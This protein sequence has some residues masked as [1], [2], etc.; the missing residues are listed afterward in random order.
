MESRLRAPLSLSCAVGS[1][2]K[3]ALTLYCARIISACIG[4]FIFPT[5]EPTKYTP[6]IR[7]IDAGLC[8][9]P[10]CNEYPER[11]D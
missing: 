4:R 5:Q 3:R 1:G 8:G 10:A 2:C 7:A 11:H 9:F 6:L